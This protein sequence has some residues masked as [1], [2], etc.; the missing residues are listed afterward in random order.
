VGVSFPASAAQNE[1]NRPVFKALQQSLARKLAPSR[2]DAIKL[3]KC[4]V[5]PF[6]RSDA[7][8][9]KSFLAFEQF[10]LRK[11]TLLIEFRP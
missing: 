9:F 3:F 11:N 6:D 2:S 5:K 1:G 7:T 10:N 8:L 4:S